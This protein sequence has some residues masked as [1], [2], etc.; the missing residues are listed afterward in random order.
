MNVKPY[1]M[2]EFVPSLNFYAKSKE[3]KK[4]EVKAFFE[5]RQQFLEKCSASMQPYDPL[6]R[7]ICA[8][9][10]KVKLSDEKWRPILKKVCKQAYC[11]GD[12]KEEFCFKY[13]E[14]KD[15][16]ETQH[17]PPTAPDEII[18]RIVNYLVL[19]MVLVIVLLMFLYNE[20]N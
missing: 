3:E 16:E 17:K 18:R 11:M 9:Y 12:S 6:V 8:N 4:E 15:T 19:I 1:D 7:G 13:E 2:G 20:T 10:D 5:K 14:N